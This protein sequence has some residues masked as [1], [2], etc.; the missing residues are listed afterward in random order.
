[1]RILFLL[2][3]SI[4][5]L[6]VYGQER[7]GESFQKDYQ[8]HITKIK[9]PIKIDG[10][11]DEPIWQNAQM[12]SSFWQKYPDDKN[13]ATQKTEVRTAYDDK[14]IY[15]SYTAY[16]SGKQFIQSLKRD[17]GHD[18]NDCVAVI[19]DPINTRNNGFFFIVNAFNA[20]SEDQLVSTDDGLS[21]SWDQ[22]WYSATKR[23]SDRW[24]A[25]M[26][27]P[28]K[29]IRYQADKKLWGI[30]FLRVDTKSNEYNVWTNLPVNFNS[31]DLGY[32]GSLIW[33]E[34]P[35]KPGTNGV[36]VPFITSELDQDNI[37]KDP[38][39]LTAN[40]G[41][42]AKFGLTPSLNLDLTVNPDFSQIEVDQQ[43]TN[44][45]RFN[46]FFPERRTFFLENADLFA[47]YGIEPI[48]PFYSRRIGL[49]PNGNR[50]PILFGARITGNLAKKT[51][52]GFMN[53]QTGRKD[54][55]APEN[56]TA[57]SID[58]RILKRSVLKGY[59]LNKQSFMT[60]AEKKANP[61]NEYGR[62]AG[63]E[64]QYSDLAGK[65]SG[66]ATYHHA[67]KPTISKEN[68]YYS[69]GIGYN[70]RNFGLIQ[71]FT[72]VGT[73]Y[74]ADMGF[75]ERIENYD[76]IRDTIIRVG[77]K[78]SYTELKYRVIP[79]KGKIIG[80]N[81][82]VE[83]FIVFNPDNSFNERNTSASF[84]MQFRSTENLN[85]GINNSEVQLQFPISF[86]GATPLPIGHYLY[87]DAEI[88]YR[89]DFRKNIGFNLNG[90][91]GQFYNGKRTTLRAGFFIR[92]LPHVNLNF[93]VQ[94]NNISFPDPYGGAE[95]F[96]ITQ[97][98]EINFT[99]NLFWTTFF[100]YNTQRNN[101]NI[102][103]R[104]QYRFKPMSDLFVV[105][106]DNYFTDPLFKS[107]NRAI[108]LKLNYWLNL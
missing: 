51:R 96:L 87:S 83:N 35:P 81:Y 82:N 100:Q 7:N 44:L 56:N 9:E 11:L 102:N 26:A 63:L 14:F 20:Q 70:G 107:K 92:K 37:N 65:W 5:S 29:S 34:P 75:I 30:N 64:F 71:D 46:I 60:D 61:L 28:F 41:F 84:N 21:F 74:Y 76:A 73:N 4:G 77:Y 8:I 101:F 12:V 15:I 103:S 86:T 31:Y 106:T 95:I 80:Y 104:L 66:W 32:T 59:F 52:I 88:S 67:I 53:M 90:G 23:Y 17:N 105:Y 98:T 99:T 94:Y 48:R 18:N 22:T 24:T 33:D 78:Q 47:G 38:L 27:I 45:S 108:V 49:D 50:I 1:M 39:K 54:D 97:R 79:T 85:F 43:V 58:Q 62:N 57:I 40:A 55:F 16:D 13:K 6:I 68:Q 2:I 89:S 91:Y 42:D 25:E 19:L 36:L 72:H 3:F 69:G 93:N 10:E